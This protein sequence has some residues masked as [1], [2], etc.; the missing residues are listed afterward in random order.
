MQ[1]NQSA[2][3]VVSDETQATGER[4]AGAAGGTEDDCLTWLWRELYA[5][6]GVHTPCRPCGQLRKFHRVKGRRAFACD[7]CG[8]HIYPTSGTFLERSGIGL[9][10][11]FTAVALT[12][13][14]DGRTPA[15]RLARELSVSYRTALRMR[16]RILDASQAGGRQ[17][18]LIMRMR[19]RVEASADPVAAPRRA[20]AGRSHADAAMDN[21]RAAACKTFAR[22]GLAEARIKDIAQEAGVSS[23]TVHYYFKSKEQVLLA[24]LEW[25]NEQWDVK[26]LRIGQETP[27]PIEALRR[28]LLWCLPL[29]GGSRDYY[30]LWLETWVASK[31]H[32]ELVGPCAAMSAE[33]ESFIQTIVEAG[34]KT[35][36]FAPVAPAS[37][38]AK[39]IATMITGLSLKSAVGY[40]RWAPEHTS[41][42]LLR[43][44]AEQLGFPPSTL[45]VFSP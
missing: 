21:I 11:W 33:F 7:H 14:S 34:T 35:G 43:F 3:L 2:D 37:E 32:P 4:A 24:A 13:E 8:M 18:E 44:A 39:R 38:V 25:S 19:D 22:R 17:A 45:G 29:D 31:R 5:A 36:V 41:Q 10:K 1:G 27:S 42:I 9:S 28:Y 40:E 20:N 26:A 23:A 12:V 6:D 15:K 16:E 30:H